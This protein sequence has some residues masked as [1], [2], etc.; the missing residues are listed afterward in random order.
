MREFRL[1]PALTNGLLTHVIDLSCTRIPLLAR[2]GKT[3]RMHHLI[4]AGAH[5]DAVLTLVALELPQW[6]LR[7]LML[8]DGQWHCTLSRQ[9]NLPIEFDQ[10]ADGSHEN[11]AV[12]MMMAFVEALGTTRADGETVAR[13]VPATPIADYAICCDNFR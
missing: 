3:A 11:A 7:R 6:R 2:A 8:D 12:A 5:V 4:G 13:V 10:T 9:R 1:A